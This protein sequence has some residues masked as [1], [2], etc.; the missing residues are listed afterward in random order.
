ML[1]QAALPGINCI[2][3]QLQE[4]G[5]LAAPRNSVIQALDNLTDPRNGSGD[6]SAAAAAASAGGAPRAADAAWGGL[7]AHT[8]AALAGALEEGAG[9]CPE[10]RSI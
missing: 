7:L 8:S 6:G 5:A 10:N 2:P 3:A 9:D 1:S 4:W